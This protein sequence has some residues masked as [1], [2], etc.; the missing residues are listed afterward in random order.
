MIW[1]RAADVYISFIS[2]LIADQIKVIFGSNVFLVNLGCPILKNVAEIKLFSIG[3]MLIRKLI[4]YNQFLKPSMG[5]GFLMGLNEINP[6]LND[7]IAVKND[8]FFWKSKL[9]K[10]N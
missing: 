7:L 10:Y 2:K 4:G 8:V 6:E 1:R 9:I 5:Q 3:V